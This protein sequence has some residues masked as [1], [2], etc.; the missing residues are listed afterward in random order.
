M[1]SIGLSLAIASLPGISYCLIEMAKK[2]KSPT[3]NNDQP[4]PDEVNLK[5]VF[6]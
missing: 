4:T 1:N 5:H 6:A 3:E 2:L